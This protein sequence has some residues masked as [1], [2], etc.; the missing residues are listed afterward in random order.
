[1]NLTGTGTS[2]RICLVGGLVVKL[3]VILFGSSVSAQI[4]PDATLGTEGSRVT[5]GVD[6]QGSPGDRIDG[7]AARGANLFHSFQEFNV[8]DGQRVYFVNPA[9]IENI[10][11]RVTGGNGSDILGTLGVLGNA[12]LFLVN[13]NGIVFGPDARLDVAGSFVAS[14]GNGFNFPDGSTFSATNPAAPP[15][16]TINLTPGLQRGTQPL[17]EINNAGNLEVDT[18]QTLAL[19]GGDVT[20]TGSLIAPGGTVMVLGDRIGLLDNARIDVSSETGGGTVLI[21]GGFQGKGAVPNAIRTLVDEGVQIEADA[22]STGE[23]GTVIVWA[24]EV[25]G[26]YGN[27]SARGGTEFGNGGFVEVSGKE[28]LI[29]RG[30]V[31][32]NAINGDAGT[33]LLDPVNII[34]ANGT[35]DTG[36]DGDDTFAGNNSG[37]VGSIFSIPLSQLDDTAS[38]TIYES[39]LEGLAGDTNIVLQATNDITIEDLADDGLV[40]QAGEGS[41]TLTAD[42]DANGMGSVVMEDTASDTLNTNGRNLRISGANLT[43]GD[44]DTSFVPLVGSDEPTQNVVVNVNAGGAIADAT[45]NSDTFTVTP[46]TTTFLFSVS[47]AGSIS[48]LDVRFSAEHTWNS[49]LTVFLES[50]QG[51]KLSL[52]TGVGGDG[53]N[54]QDTLLNDEAPTSINQGETSFDGSFKPLGSLAGFDGENSNGDWTLT[55]TDTALADD[56]RLFQAG[57]TAPWGTATG[58]QLIFELGTT[59]PNNPVARNSGSLTLNAT[60]GNISTGNLNTAND[61]GAGGE[62]ILDA[63]GDITTVNVNSFSFSSEGNGGAINLDAGGNLSVNHI[64]SSS[65]GNG[66]AIN[67]DAGGNISTGTLSSFSSSEDGGAIALTASGSINLN[68][69]NINSTSINGKGGNVTIRSGSTDPSQAAI[70]LVDTGI[71]AAAFDSKGGKTGDI[72]LEAINGGSVQLVGQSTQP[73]IFT[74]TFGNTPGGNLTI[75]GGSI[76]IDNYALIADVNAEAIGNGGNILVKT[77]DTGQVLIT[78]ETEISTTTLGAG[79]AGNLTI[80]TGHLLVENASLTV[81]SEVIASGQAGNIS[82][83]ANSLR[84]NRGILKAETLGN[85]S[86]Q[87]QEGANIDIT[88]SD[89]LFM[90]NESLISAR[91]EG[92]ANG[93]N[94]TIDTPLLVVLPPTGPDGSD[95]IASASEGNGGTINITA[96]GVIG[97]GNRQA[98]GVV[99][100][101]QRDAVSGN[102]TNDIDAKSELGVSGEVNI[103]RAFDPARGLIELPEEPVDSTQL[104]SQGC[105]GGQRVA[106]DENEFIVTGRGGLPYSPDNLFGGERVLTD[107]GTPA[108]ST[109]SRTSDTSIASATPAPAPIVEAQGWVVDADGTVR[110]VAQAPQ[111]TPQSPWQPT[112]ECP[113]SE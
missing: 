107:L 88:L 20:S 71:D 105:S 31:D 42:A 92:D 51:T 28:H 49:D 80:E 67:L 18:G 55:V 99:G 38:T 9:G 60:N 112:V 22:L 85:V 89:S 72:T 79:N 47:E 74:D 96:R 30:N 12:N 93:G 33:L 48:D 39:E 37:T 68:N 69:I 50:P 45:L 56:G 109:A 14:T 61:F 75:S 73:R 35:G 59:Q 27:I 24:D 78:N 3:G 95:I 44:I 1:M 32:T 17:E 82:I 91:A 100:I 76:T 5:E 110:L 54:F 66:G 7:G 62:I 63:T 2:A 111:V 34:I 23:G 70:R 10:L 57:E 46:T 102:R 41:I 86:S 11:S 58:T 104:I 13:P 6:V 52:F 29:F 84:L 97:V 36:N 40:F 43:L 81:T 87:Q 65:E 15:L 103:N 94:I 64:D 16:L 90:E 101:D 19:Y 53:D 8:S 106:V 21:G 77:P 113:D 26:F 108:T 4:I 25:T 98:S 83:A